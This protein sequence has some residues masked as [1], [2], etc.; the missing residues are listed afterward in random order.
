MKKRIISFALALIMLVS[1]AVPVFADSSKKKYS[2][3]CAIG[4]S[5]STGYGPLD[6]YSWEGHY[7]GICDRAYPGLVRTALGAEYHSLTTVAS[8]LIDY[9]WMLNDIS[10]KKYDYADAVSYHGQGYMDVIDG[11]RGGEAEKRIKQ[12]SLI[13]INLGNIDVFIY[14][15]H[16]S[17]VDGEFSIPTF[18]KKVINGYESF[19]ADYPKLIK[20]IQEINPSAEI[21]LVGQYNPF[22]QIEFTGTLGKAY[23]VF[24]QEVFD[25]LNANLKLCA[26]LNGCAYVDVTE[27]ASTFSKE[28][29]TDE[30]LKN[31]ISGHENHPNALG[32]AMMAEA[33]LNSLPDAWRKVLLPK[34]GIDRIEIGGLNAGSY[35]IRS[36][37][38]GWTIKT[39]DG[40]YV[41]CDTA[42][43]NITYG[44]KATTY[45]TYFGGFCTTVAVPVTY[46]FVTGF[47]VSVRQIKLVYLNV[48]REGQLYTSGKTATNV[49]VAN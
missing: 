15:M 42:T 38:L 31:V 12:S 30:N 9:L 16:T 3:Y 7:F 17:T 48:D 18:M 35:I 13:T 2:D 14:P 26:K 34:N 21:L 40:R 44:S 46:R 43:G 23:A 33:I 5:I 45:W 36:S 22:A 8:R 32:H 1:L 47:T 29:V 49:Y 39:L 37:L 19:I 24:I 20:R 25:N 4:D 41:N 11:L 28:T 27:V 6:G 10:E